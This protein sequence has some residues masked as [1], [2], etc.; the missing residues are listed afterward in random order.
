M[1]NLTVFSFKT[2][3]HPDLN[4]HHNKYKTIQKLICHLFINY[5]FFF[6]KQPPQVYKIITETQQAPQP[7]QHGGG[8]AAQTYII[9]TQQGGGRYFSYFGSL[10]RLKPNF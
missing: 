5:L 1:K 9:Q 3:Q 4:H 8:G 10:F 7:Q 6:N 2:D